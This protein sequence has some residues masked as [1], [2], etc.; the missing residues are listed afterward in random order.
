M[1]LKQPKMIL[2]Y[3]CPA[4][5]IDDFAD[6]VLEKRGWER[7][8]LPIGNGFIGAT[9]QGRLET[10]RVQ[11]TENSLTNK[12]V[13]KYREAAGC[14]AGGLNNFAE[15]LFDF[16]HSTASDY[17]RELSLDD[18]TACVS[19]TYRGVHY[20]RTMFASH[21]DR[22]LVMRLEADV[23]GKISVGIHPYIP[24][25]GKG[26]YEDGDGYGKSGEVSAEG[27]RI[28]LRGKMEYFGTVFEGQLRV[29]PEGGTMTTS[30]YQ[31]KI[32]VEAADAVT[33]VFG[34]A[35]NYHMEE[36]VFLEE[37]PANKLL[38]YPD[39]HEKVR[40][41]VDA[42]ATCSYQT[43]LERH[44]KDYHSIYTRMSLSLGDVYSDKMTDALLRDYQ[45]GKESRYL[46][47]LLFQYGRYL[48]IASSRTYLPANLQGIWNQYASSP[49]H[50]GYA[51][52]INV[53]MNYWMSGPAN[54]RDLF[55]PYIN[56]AKAY[57]PTARRLADR[58]VEEFYPDRYV[59]NGNNGWLIGVTANAYFVE[60]L[61]KVTHSGPG[62][63][64]LTSLLFW[65]YYDYTGDIDFLRTFA[66]PA[67]RDMSVF[68]TRV[69][70]EI[71][72]KML[73]R[74]S[75]SPENFHQGAPYHT[76]GC[77]FDQQMIYEN[78][79]RTLQAAEILNIE[80]PILEGI[81]KRMSLLDPVLLGD[82]GQIKE[83]REE[84][85]YGSIGDPNHRHVSQLMGMFP[86][87]L[88]NRKTP[89][90]LEG[91]KITLNGRGMNCANGWPL[92]HRFCLWARACDSSKAMALLRKFIQ[93]SV[94]D[95]LWANHGVFQI[96]ANFGYVS[97]VTEMLMQSQSGYIELLPSCPKEWES[98]SFSGMVAR[99]A[100][101]VD[102]T[103]ES[104]VI[105]SVKILSE[106]G[107]RL[108]IKLPEKLVASKPCVSIH[109]GIS[110]FET[111]ENETI[112]FK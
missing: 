91:A 17:I 15:L 92:I 110:E 5:A 100:F 26:L 99:G 72:G 35:T 8:S 46:E 52:N 47:M 39:P 104:G 65:D 24:F 87:T 95:N 74:D 21:P 16:N 75:A 102:C 23:P 28:T 29:L 83:Y 58:F 53:Q 80:E 93:S 6:T 106:K 44:L 84:T 40:A 34:A 107:G 82:S 77:A 38:G 12:W 70:E 54:L 86:G 27:D 64:A 67:L 42:A 88:I 45:N 32:W 22:V 36:R 66:Y 49:W 96:E 2:R 73:V 10:E 30:R 89:E 3:D 94:L 108:C 62:M 101:V 59:K 11:I 1:L 57:L 50:G 76:V 19:Y 98:G 13:R 112:I 14:P 41:M 4:P 111:T 18:A 56:Y 61:R 85:T 51:N 37:V 43:L 25:V 103:W 79:R 9:V 60:E 105:K 20:K 48:L 78:D 33:V 55:V 69:L 31:G 71:D 109:D 7:Y 90:W 81:R 68:F 97:G 63:A